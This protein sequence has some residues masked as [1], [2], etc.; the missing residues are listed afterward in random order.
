MHMINFISADHLIT[1]TMLFHPRKS[2]RSGYQNETKRQRTEGL[3]MRQE[4]DRVN[5]AFA[6][7]SKGVSG[8]VEASVC[9][10][11]MVSV[12]T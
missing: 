3:G 1:I 8:L 2:S 12:M 6:L 5:V 7:R 9:E 10:I 11:V 4:Q